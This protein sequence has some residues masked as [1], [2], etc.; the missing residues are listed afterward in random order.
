MLHAIATG[1]RTRCPI[2]MGPKRMMFAMVAGTALTIGLGARRS[3]PRHAPAK[4]AHVEAPWL[5]REASAQV[6]GPDGRLGPLFADVALGGPAPSADVRARIAEFARA[7]HV[8]IDLEV[9]DNGLV[10]VR[11]AVTFPGGFGYEGADVLALRLH[12]PSTGVCCVCGP[13][14]WINDWSM[15]TDDGTY[16]HTRINVNRVEVRWQ[17]TLSLA[18]LLERADALVDTNEREL[19]RD[20]WTAFGDTKVLRVP[21]AFY[22]TPYIPYDWDAMGVNLDIA[23]GKI[24]SADFT[25][26]D[27]DD[28]AVKRTAAAL[29]ARWGRPR[30]SKDTW[31]WRLPDRVVT[32]DLDWVPDSEYSTARTTRIRIESRDPM[33]AAQ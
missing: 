15:L 27:H 6:V 10:G 19:A 20:E 18:A 2:G 12:R 4:R 31:T 17:R 5:S 22:D 29:Q 21:Y 23:H 24:A 8:A 14:T 13:D 1:A 33:L 26:I 16:I 9:E 30:K 3:E 25:L 11:F 7:N 32:A 28:D